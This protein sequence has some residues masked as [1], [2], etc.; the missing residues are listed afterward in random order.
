MSGMEMEHAPDDPQHMVNVLQLADDDGA[1][2]ER[3]HDWGVDATGWRWSSKF[4]DLDNDGF[5]DLYVVNGMIEER[6][7]AHL[8]RHELVEANQAFRNLDGAGFEPAPRMGP[9]LPLQRS[10]LRHRRL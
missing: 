1:F 10:R 2:S 5:L 8:P 3:G 4:G 7:F 6:M 9:R